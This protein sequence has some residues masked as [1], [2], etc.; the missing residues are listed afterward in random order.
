M[1]TSHIQTLRIMLRDEKGIFCPARRTRSLLGSLP[2][3][4]L[5]QCI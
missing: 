1:T 5:G 3:S 2:I 4:A